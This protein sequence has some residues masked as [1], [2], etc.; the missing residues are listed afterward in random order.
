MRRSVTAAS[1]IL[2]GMIVVACGG[3][4]GGGGGTGGAPAKAACVNAGAA[5]HAYVV[6]E[7]QNGREVQRCVG[8]DGAGIGG[9]QLMKKSGIELQTQTYSFGKAVCQLDHEPKSF[10][11]CLPK[12][13][14]YWSMFVYRKGAGWQTPQT[15]YT[16]V[17]VSDGGALGWRYVPA[18][19]ASPS[20]PPAPSA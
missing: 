12:N 9:E 20:P 13:A 18:S 15:G 14:P 2:A 17:T 8:F 4:G 6:V 1:A 5:H 19:E 11:Q 3:S 16:G 10:S 7:H